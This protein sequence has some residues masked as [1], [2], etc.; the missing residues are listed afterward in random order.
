MLLR[1]LVFL[2][3]PSFEG[4]KA[5]CTGFPV[6]FLYTKKREEKKNLCEYSHILMWGNYWEISE[7]WSLNC[8]LRAL[9]NPLVT[10]CKIVG[11]K[12]HCFDEESNQTKYKCCYNLEMSPCIYPT[13]VVLSFSSLIHDSCGERYLRILHKHAFKW[14]SFIVWTSL[15]SSIFFPYCSFVTSSVKKCACSKPL[16]ACFKFCYSHLHLCLLN[17]YPF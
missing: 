10:T 8:E 6:F 2:A 16:F 17:L 4:E 9:C 12:S 13:H 5:D 3:I 1:L 11:K 7:V 15:A 14:P